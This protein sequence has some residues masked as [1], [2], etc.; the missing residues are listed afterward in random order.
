MKSASVTI[1]KPLVTP[2]KQTSYFHKRGPLTHVPKK[3][4][5]AFLDKH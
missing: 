2:W 3:N 4:E 1:L 5:H